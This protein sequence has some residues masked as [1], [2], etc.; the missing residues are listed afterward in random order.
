MNAGDALGIPD[1]GHLPQQALLVRARAQA[2]AGVGTKARA[3]A[4]VNAHLYGIQQTESTGASVAHRA[5]A[6][7]PRMNAKAKDP[8]P[9]VFLQAS[10]SRNV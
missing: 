8:W 6:E 10:A 4:H 5:T 2:H 9:G 7:K 1:C 3:R